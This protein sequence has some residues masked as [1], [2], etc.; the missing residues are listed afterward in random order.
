MVALVTRMNAGFPG[1][2]SRD[3]G[4]LLVE[5]A[6]LA[7]SGQP[8]AYGQFVKL[9]SGLVEAIASGDAATAV[10]GLLVAPYPVQSTTNAMG[11]AT[12]PTSGI[13]DVM[14]RGYAIVTL[15]SGSAVK[16][17]PVYLVTTAASGHVVGAVDAAFDSGV[18]VAINAIFTGP[19]DANGNVEIYLFAV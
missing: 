8:T 2:I 19:A 15:E 14:R 5:P 11:A 3:D 17:A 13:V 4:L 1:R 7:A 12:P 9:V 6:E 10:Y 18:N 16:G